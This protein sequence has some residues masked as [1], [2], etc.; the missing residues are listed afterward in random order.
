[1]RMG[2]LWYP[3]WAATFSRVMF[4]WSDA[5]KQRQRPRVRTEYTHTQ[6][7]TSHDSRTAWESNH[8]LSGKDCCEEQASSTPGPLS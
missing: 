8:F 2:N 6:G 7:L 5:I 4:V 3:G 1:M